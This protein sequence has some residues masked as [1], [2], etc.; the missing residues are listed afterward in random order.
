MTYSVADLTGIA[1]LWLG[2]MAVAVV[3]WRRYRL[4]VFRLDSSEALPPPYSALDKALG[5]VGTVVVLGG[6]VVLLMD[7]ATET[8]RSG[9]DG[10][11]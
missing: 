2:T 4:G 10:R 9:R 5:A 8:G 7:A 6:V 3:L 1:A 11:Q